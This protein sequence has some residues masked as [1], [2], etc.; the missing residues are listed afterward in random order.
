MSEKRRQ[1]MREFLAF[2]IVSD[3]CQGCRDWG[4]KLRRATSLSGDVVADPVPVPDEI[5]PTEA[6]KQKTDETEK[7]ESESCSSESSASG[8]EQ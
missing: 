6:K 4:R 5:Q 2:R 8:D 7:S 1:V 3:M